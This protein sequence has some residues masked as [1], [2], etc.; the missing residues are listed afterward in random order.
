MEVAGSDMREL[1][2]LYSPYGLIAVMIKQGTTENIYYAETDQLV[3]IISL[4]NSDGSSAEKDLYDAGGRRRNPDSWSYESITALSLIDRGFTGHEY[5]DEFGLINMNGRVYDP[6]LG[7]FLSP[8]NFVQSPDFTQSINRYLSDFVS[9][10]P[11]FFII[12]YTLA[13]H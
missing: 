6:I 11:G 4:L 10:L 9:T 1:H 13:S 2:Y 8:D 12:A 7:R 3:P 5:L